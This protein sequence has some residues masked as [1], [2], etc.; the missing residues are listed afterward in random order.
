MPMHNN[1]ENWLAGLQ[2][3]LY[4]AKKTQGKLQQPVD[5]APDYNSDDLGEDAN[6]Y[7]NRV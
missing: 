7:F 2:F 6:A 5:A 1:F 3:G 4:Q